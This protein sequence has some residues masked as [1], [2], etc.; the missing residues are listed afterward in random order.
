METTTRQG[1]PLVVTLEAL[2]RVKGGHPEPILSFRYPGGILC[3][4]YYLSTF[5]SIEGLCLEGQGTYCHELS[6]D[7]VAMLQFAISDGLL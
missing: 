1:K 4:S 6:P 5:Q 3:S 2:Q 7:S